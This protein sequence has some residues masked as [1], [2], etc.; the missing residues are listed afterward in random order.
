MPCNLEPEPFAFAAAP[1]DL[2]NCG[3]RLPPALTPLAFAVAAA[4][5]NIGD[6]WPLVCGAGRAAA[7]AGVRGVVLGVGLGAA[8]AIGGGCL[9][10]VLVIGGVGFGSTFGGNC[11]L[12]CGAALTGGGGVFGA[13]AAIGSGTI[14][15]GCGGAAI[16]SALL[17][18]SLLVSA[19]SLSCPT[20]LATSAMI[21][22]E[23]AGSGLVIGVT[24]QV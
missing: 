14:S 21:S 17:A 4:I 18:I 24:F 7:G 22:T 11:L 13:G 10:A 23:I 12:I 19:S 5:S 6:A 8:L 1:D 9:G 2:D 20:V 16:G 15:S 3:A